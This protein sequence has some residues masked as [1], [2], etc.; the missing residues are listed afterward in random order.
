[1]LNQKPSSILSFY[2]LTLAIL[3]IGCSSINYESD[4]PD[5]SPKGKESQIVWPILT[6]IEPNSITAGSTV[7]ISG[8]DGYVIKNGDEITNLSKSFAAMFNGE[9]AGSII[10]L[11]KSCEGRFV[12]PTNVQIGDHLITTE[13][14]SQLSIKVTLD[15][16]ALTKIRERLGYALFP[17]FLPK[18]IEFVEAKVSGL[19]GHLIFDEGNNQINISFPVTFSKDG[20][21]IQGDP[22]SPRRPHDAVKKIS[23]REN[24]GY[25]IKGKWSDDTIAMG[26]FIEPSMAKWEYEGMWSLYWDTRVNRSNIGVVI[27]SQSNIDEPNVTTILRQMAASLKEH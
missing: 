15:K 12:V 23:I 21:L 6:K 3:L 5:I 10:C 24:Q 22:N 17:A 2:Y 18:G 26:P 16:Q 7:A 19:R 4:L 25:L 27:Q 1:M 13:G 20:S 11:E 14:G 9:E 8:I